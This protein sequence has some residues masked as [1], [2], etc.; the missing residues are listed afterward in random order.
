MKTKFLKIVGG[1]TIAYRLSKPWTRV[2]DLENCCL[3]ASLKLCAGSVEM[4]STLSLTLESNVAKVLEQVV[5]PTPPL[6][7]T[8]IQR[9]DFL[10]NRFFTV[11][12]M[13]SSISS[14]R[15]NSSKAESSKSS[16]MLSTSSTKVLSGTDF[17]FLV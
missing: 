14:S 4:I 16:A 7:P 12:L 9:S 17:F 13:G 3:K 11:G 1:R 5:L 10:S 8:K 6:P 15:S 2:G